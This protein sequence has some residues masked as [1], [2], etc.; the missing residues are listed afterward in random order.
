MR[1]LEI[2]RHR[3]YTP[4]AAIIMPDQ[5]QISLSCL[6]NKLRQGTGAF[7]QEVVRRAWASGDN[8]VGGMRVGPTKGLAF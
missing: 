7:Q 2:K 5:R 3:C 4:S 6:Q 8:I 1:K